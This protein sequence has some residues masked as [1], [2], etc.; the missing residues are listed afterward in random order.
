VS[1]FTRWG[2]RV[3]QV[4]VKSRVTDAPATLRDELLGAIPA[5]LERHPILGLDP[6][7][8]TPPLGTPGPWSERL[9]HFR[10]GFTPSNGD[11]IQS[12]YLLPRRH[13]VAAIRALRDLAGTIR[14]VLQV[15]EL[16]TIAADSLWMSPQHGQAT[17]GIHFTWKLDQD[18]VERALVDVEAAL[19][20]FG[21]RPHWGKL[22]LAEAAAV[23]PLYE[24]LDDF[25]RLVERLDPRGAFRNDWLDAH[26]LGGA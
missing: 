8:C 12:E 17:L 13:A 19:A 16:R 2:D 1:V 15:S 6:V 22:F 25:A 10:M 11:E 20:P 26:V 18:A 21:A 5:T 9:P 3:D 4:W 7:N 23:G 14:P 24:R